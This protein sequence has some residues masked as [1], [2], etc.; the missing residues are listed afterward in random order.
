MNW[1]FRKDLV[2][3]ITWIGQR[4]GLGKQSSF[5][6]LTAYS[7]IYLTQFTLIS[8]AAQKES[9]RKDIEGVFLPPDCELLGGNVTG[10]RIGESMSI[11]AHSD[12]FNDGHLSLGPGSLHRN[13]DDLV[14][15]KYIGSINET[16]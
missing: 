13:R 16:P 10:K 6:N 5:Q 11:H 15:C 8:H 7:L 9:L 4:R 12:S 2:R 3:K 1:R 14:H